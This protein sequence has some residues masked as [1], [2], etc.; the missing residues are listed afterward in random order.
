MNTKVYNKGDIIFRQGDAG[1][2]MFDIRGGRVGI[3]LDYGTEQQKL[4]TEL[5]S[6]SF[7]GEIGMIDHVPRSATAVALKDKTALL[8]ITEDTLGEL[9]RENSEKVFAIVRQL[10]DRLRDLT[11][12]YMEVCRTAASIKKI[13]ERPKEADGKAIE[14]A[15]EKAAR[16][17]ADAHHTEYV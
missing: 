14:E 12:N 6:G 16:F 4:L 15:K 10:A 17:E 13:E 8:E 5:G 7:F 1:E 2:S 3:Y 11:K 9:L